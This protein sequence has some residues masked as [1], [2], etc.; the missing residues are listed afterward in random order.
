MKY[1]SLFILVILLC[2]CTLAQKKGHNATE[3]ILPV[4]E[5]SKD[6]TSPTFAE[7]IGVNGGLFLSGNEETLRKASIFRN[8]RIFYLMGHDMK[9]RLPKDFVPKPCMT[10]CPNISCDWENTNAAWKFRLCD[11]SLLFETNTISLEVFEGTGRNYPNRFYRANELGDAYKTGFAYGQTIGES[12]EGLITTVEVGNEPHGTPGIK[13][14]NQWSKGLAEGV[15]SKSKTM[16]ICSAD[17]QNSGPDYFGK[18]LLNNQVKDI[19]TSLFDILQVHAYAINDTFRVTLPPETLR[20]E[21]SDMYPYRDKTLWLGEVGWDSN[22]LG[23][24]TQ[25]AYLLRIIVL[26]MRHDFD[27][28]F[29]Y[30]II[31]DG[32]WAAPFDHC[33][34]L[35]KDSSEKKSYRLLK[36]MVTEFGDYRISEIIKDG[37]NGAY[38][39]GF[40]DG[41]HKLVIAWK[42]GDRTVPRMV[43]Q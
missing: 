19:D 5:R 22:L 35:N 43:I 38:E 30:N 23:E 9:G 41:K 1:P 4:S 8:N 21:L 6:I 31:D 15:R 37:E 36:R 39:Y 40:T 28:V 17:I 3:P 20:K 10:K 29:V 33:G 27:K 26:A 2:S 7:V 32:P 12:L 11:W 18:T 25:A 24:E 14:F 16:K 42:E 13:T 34:I